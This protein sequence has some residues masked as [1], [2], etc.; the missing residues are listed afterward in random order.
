MNQ[1]LSRFILF[2]LYYVSLYAV[3]G[4]AEAAVAHDS[5][6]QH[7]ISCVEQSSQ[8]GIAMKDAAVGV[9]VGAALSRGTVT[10]KVSILE[11]AS[12]DP[13]DPPC[14]GV[15]CST[16]TELKQQSVSTATNQVATS[17]A[18][19]HTAVLCHSRYVMTDTRTMVDSANLTAHPELVSVGIDPSPILGNCQCSQTE[20]ILS[21]N[22]S[23]NTNAPVSRTEIGTVTETQALRDHS[24][25][26]CTAKVKSRGTSVQP[27]V[28]DLGVNT[29]PSVRHTATAMDSPSIVTQLT[30]TP[31]PHV[32]DQACSPVPITSRSISV[33][34]HVAG[35]SCETSTVDLIVFTS[36][37]SQTYP[38]LRMDAAC[39]DFIAEANSV[40][41]GTDTV[42][43]QTVSTNTSQDKEG[44]NVGVNTARNQR[45]S[46]CSPMLPSV[47]SKGCGTDRVHH[48]NV[49]LYV[50]PI[51]RCGSSM[52]E[53]ER[54]EKALGDGN[55]RVRNIGVNVNQSGVDDSTDTYDLVRGQDCYTNTDG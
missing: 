36:T 50:H 18:T 29:K 49:G 48:R 24:T 13:M 43:Y 1:L 25:Q 39:G 32:K 31:R 7:T 12:G 30:Q 46:W 35:T 51:T 53:I 54:S 15:D 9:S 23:T 52:T 5:Q 41:C 8:T 27:E 19:T 42:T 17:N 26:T 38:V 6:S 28:S 22:E 11:K 20:A 4:E 44:V 21:K 37:P 2:L 40:L 16:L 55:V 14:A 10:D 47:S 45:D 34:A 3:L 33:A